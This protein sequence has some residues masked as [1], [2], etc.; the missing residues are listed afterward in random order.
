MID[1]FVN[2]PVY[3]TVA[4]SDSSQNWFWMFLEDSCH[5]LKNG[6]SDQSFTSCVRFPALEIWRAML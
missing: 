3:S 2:L 1:H 4:P 5:Y 6:M